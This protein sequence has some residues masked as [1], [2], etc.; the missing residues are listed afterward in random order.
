MGEANARRLT[1]TAEVFQAPFAARI[2]LIHESVPA[3]QSGSS[4]SII[5]S[6]HL[7]AAGPNALAEGKRLIRDVAGRPIDDA[8]TRDTAARIARV[9]ASD[10]GQEGIAAFFEKRPP[11]WASAS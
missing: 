8:L 4:S 3:E 2:G 9:R 5:L 1:L 6:R 11:N 10:E 7:L